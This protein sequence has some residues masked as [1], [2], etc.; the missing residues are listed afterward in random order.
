MDI[1]NGLPSLPVQTRTADRSGE[2]RVTTTVVSIKDKNGERYRISQNIMEWRPDTPL[3]G[4]LSLQNWLKSWV[5]Q[6]VWPEKQ[7]WL[8]RYVERGL[9]CVPD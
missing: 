8:E 4:V 2:V 6:F 3:S 5:T 7:V 1:Y 9:P